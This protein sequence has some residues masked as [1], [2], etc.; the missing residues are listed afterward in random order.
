VKAALVRIAGVI[1]CAA[2]LVA[3]AAYAPLVLKR[4]D[5]FDVERVDVIG[6]RHLS[7]EDAVA[8]AG[9]TGT[10]SVFADEAAWLSGLLEH[11]LVADAAVERRVPG[12]VVLH[13]T[14]SQPVA[15]AR[16]P[17]LRPIDARGRL[18]PVDPGLY[19]MDLPV[20]SLATRVSAAGRADD[21]PTLRVVAFLDDVA[22][23]EPALIGWISEAG[24]RGADVRLVLRTAH[25]AEV[26]LPAVADPARLRELHYTLVELATPRLSSVAGGAAGAR[27]RVADA[28]L[29]RV[30]R[31]D[32]RFHDQVV[33]AM[34]GGKD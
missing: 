15:L 21:E 32:V 16:T 2:V 7:A 25:D 11:P 26:L 18:L 33:V 23:H 8:A 12:T 14:E 29:S 19:D 6:A 31:I 22:R 34:H 3:A 4:W 24:V 1:G 13:I 5:A 17:E 27:S 20:L 10:T 28:D 9:I 30:R